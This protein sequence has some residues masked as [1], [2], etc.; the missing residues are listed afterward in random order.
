MESNV[1]IVRRFYEG[2]A[3]GDVP[4]LLGLMD[5]KV[6]WTEA[7]GFFTGGTYVGPNAVVEGVFVPL[8]TEI[9]GFSAAPDEI[10]GCGEDTV[11]GLGHYSGAFK[12]TGKSFRVPFAH[13]WRLTG[14]KVM[15]F[16]QYTD[17]ALVQQAL[18]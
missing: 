18:S 2:V 3:Q 11:V 9:D 15:K 12:A 8:A 17:T 5:E 6:D 4:T 13:I 1:E 7:E 14:G 10:L 16:E